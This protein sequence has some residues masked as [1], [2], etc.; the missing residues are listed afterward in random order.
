LIAGEPWWRR[1]LGL[2]IVAGVAVFVVLFTALRGMGLLDTW[3]LRRTHARIVRENERLREENARLRQE[4]HRLGT[5][6]AYIEE[7]ARRELGLI[8]RNENVIVLDPAA[9]APAGPP[10]GGGPGRP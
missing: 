8:G 5:N 1:R 6:P 3:R 10:A 7:I 4:A 9:K 2:L